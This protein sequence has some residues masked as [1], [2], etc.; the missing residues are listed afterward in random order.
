MLKKKAPYINDYIPPVSPVHIQP[1]DTG[2]K[3]VG[4]SYNNFLKSFSKKTDN[5]NNIM[6]PDITWDMNSKRRSKKERKKIKKKMFLKKEYNMNNLLDFSKWELKES[7]NFD[8]YE[9]AEEYKEENRRYLNLD[10]VRKTK[11]YR[12]I[13]RFGFKETTSKQQKLN[14]TLKFERKKTNIKEEENV[15]YTIH[16]TGIVRRYNP[17]KGE[18]KSQGNGNIIKN[19]YVP[20]KKP[21]DYKKGLSYLLQYLRRKEI[22]NNYE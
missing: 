22:K 14:N 2:F 15:F 13:I 16:P 3:I 12:R 9:P 7:N 1:G 20:F 17:P 19:F 10:L 8:K 5:K 4:K 6:D 18:E 21:S 11:E